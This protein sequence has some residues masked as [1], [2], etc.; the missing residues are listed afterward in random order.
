MKALFRTSFV[1]NL[2]HWV[3]STGY[4]FF[5]AIFFCMIFYEIITSCVLSEKFGARFATYDYS[6]FDS[7]YAFNC[8]LECLFQRTESFKLDNIG[9]LNKSHDNITIILAL[10]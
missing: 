5:V 4:Q 8:Y 7:T 10:L 3:L 1:S 2:A 6:N 9:F